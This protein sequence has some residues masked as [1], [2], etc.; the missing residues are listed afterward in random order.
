M[1]LPKIVIT[2]SEVYDMI[3]HHYFKQAYTDSQKMRGQKYA[4]RLQK[5]WNKKSAKILKAMSEVSGL[6]WKYDIIKVYPIRYGYSEIAWPLTIF[7]YKDDNHAISIIIHELCHVLIEQNQGKINWKLIERRYKNCNALTRDHLLVH[8]ICKLT[9][10]KV[11]RDASEPFL[12]Y[13][14][15][16]E[17]DKWELANHYKKSW[18]IVAKK[19]PENIIK[20]HLK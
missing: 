3:N 8:A 17:W 12:K 16:W 11:F 4:A 5:I 19:W 2:Y 10:E 14:R 18:D 7:F 1:L 9:T 13:E 15:F 6:K 20:E